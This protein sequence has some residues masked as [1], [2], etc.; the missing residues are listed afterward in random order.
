MAVSLSF[1][2]LGD[3]SEADKTAFVDLVCSGGEVMKCTLQ[4]NVKTAVRLVFL[5]DASNLIGVAALKIPIH[6]YRG[7]LCAKTGI[8]LD[9]SEVPYEVGYILVKETA[10][11][12]GHSNVLVSTALA[13]AGGQGVFATSRIDN[14][15]MHKTLARF[16]FEKA[17]KP[18]VG[19]DAK[20][21]IQLFLRRGQ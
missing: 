13:A 10:R 5:R 11:G 3:F 1:G 17:G 4:Q 8:L 6:T 12:Q 18:Y 9:D 21:M 19:R 20:E 2:S 15:P 7:T 16:G 14:A